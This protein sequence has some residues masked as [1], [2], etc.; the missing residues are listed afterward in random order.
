MNGPDTAL[1]ST[2]VPEPGAPGDERLR[3][4]LPEDAPTVSFAAELPYARLRK[5][6]TRQA[7]FLHAHWL[8]LVILAAATAVRAVA[9]LGYGPGLWYPDSLPYVQA[10]LDPVPYAVRPIGY[11]FLLWALAIGHSVL[12]VIIVQHLMGLATGALVYC[13]LRR[14]RLPA[15]GSALAS[16][17]ALLSAYAIQVEHFVL[18]DAFF[19]LLVMVTL[20]L[21]LWRPRPHLWVCCTVGLLLALAALDRSQGMLLAVPFVLYLVVAR[22]GLRRLLLSAAVLSL[23]FLVP[24][25]AYCWWFDQ[26]QGSFEITTST[27]AFLYSRVAGFADCSVDKPP[28]DERWL[29]VNTPPSLR[30]NENWYVW[31]PQSPLAH[32]PSWEFGPQVNHLA[33]SFALRAIKAQPLAYLR[34][35]WDS[36]AETFVPEGYT[37]RSQAIYFFPA[38][39]PESLKTTAAKNAEDPGYGYAYNGGA[40]PSTTLTQP[41]ASWIR[42]YQ[43]YI[44]VPGPFLGCIVLVGLAGAVLAW[45]RGGPTW[46]AWLTGMVLIVTPA[47]TA[48]YDARYVIASIPVFC[49]AAAFALREIDFRL[50]SLRLGG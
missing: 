23:S 24:V 2:F 17:P 3:E 44:T 1:A 37:N 15:W 28:A 6:R 32:G 35:V 38:T 18:A 33:T 16:V 45:R 36:A 4:P 20:A 27:G 31:A 30:Q 34:A 40:D 26:T 42:G 7:R 12:L 22:L 41:F 8:I 43:R 50:N 9:V 49:V 5:L 14:H 21:L 11:S 10:A 29:C 25:F 13:L 46:L 19:S 47:A 48:D 39:A